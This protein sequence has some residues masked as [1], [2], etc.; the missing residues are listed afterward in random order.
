MTEKVT[1]PLA[2]KLNSF[3]N[4]KG[5]CVPTHLAIPR[6]FIINSTDNAANIIPI[7]LV[8]SDALSFPITLIMRVDNNSSASV[9]NKTKSIVSEVSTCSLMV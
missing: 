1:W 8:S 3:A 7:I 2:F 4:T 9:I 6:A 5:Y